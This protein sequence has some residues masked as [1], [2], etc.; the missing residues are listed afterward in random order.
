M[1]V[2]HLN[3]GRFF[4]YS[5]LPVSLSLVLN[6]LTTPTLVDLTFHRISIALGNLLNSKADDKGTFFVPKGL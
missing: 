4:V 3:Q 2:G 6:P 1:G 5:Y